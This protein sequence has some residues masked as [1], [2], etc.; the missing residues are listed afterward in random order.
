MEFMKFL[1]S[2]EAV[3]CGGEILGSEIWKSPRLI[4]KPEGPLD[5]REFGA[6]KKK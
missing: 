1:W 2:S 3:H 5:E 4:G 6:S